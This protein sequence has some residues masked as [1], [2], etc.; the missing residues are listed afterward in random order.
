MRPFEIYRDLIVALQVTR[1]CNFKC[2]YCYIS[3]NGGGEE[4]G[5]DETRRFLAMLRQE[6]DG[7]K[8]SY[9][10]AGGEVFLR[11]WTA[12]LIEELLKEGC[13]VSV[14]SNGSVLPERLLENSR[15]NGGS[16]RFTLEISMDGLLGVHEAT[17]KDFGTVLANF[18]RI[19]SEG[20]TTCIHT[21]VHKAN[22]THMLDFSVFLNSLADEQDTEIFHAVQP[23]VRHPRQP[24]RQIASLRVP[25]EQYLEEGWRVIQYCRQFLPRVA[26]HWRFISDVE[27]LR[28]R[29]KGITLQ[30]ALFGCT[31]GIDLELRANGDL[32]SCEMARPLGNIL[33]IADRKG[34]RM[35]L[36]K[37]EHHLAPGKRCLH[38]EYRTLCG[39]CR[40]SPLVH[41]Y[42]PAF[43]YERCE[44]FF[45][46]VV[47]FHQ[48]RVSA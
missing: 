31:A 28:Q 4:V 12:P 48:E 22:L 24:D 3:R 23:L 32:L 25:L 14:V 19:L 16:G 10:F 30:S 36:H 5:P 38:C 9:H 20:I 1:D 40:L 41:G 46:D 2:P 45:G 21:T 8:I 34:L 47:A 7:W 15:S 18:T 17:R 44:D 42:V 29:R 39:M 33:R 11:D 27:T 26:S 6:L 13:V 37:L 35:F 43:G